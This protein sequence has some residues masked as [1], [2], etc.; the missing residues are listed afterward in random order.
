MLN[1]MRLMYSVHI[2]AR[3][4]IRFVS[5]LVLKTNTVEMC[6]SFCFNIPTK[7]SICS[8]ISN[9]S[10]ECTFNPGTEF[11]PKHATHFEPAYTLFQFST[12]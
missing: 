12:P 6:R 7:F 4:F 2:F 8:L 11:P 1:L 9:T 5:S 3:I 10:V